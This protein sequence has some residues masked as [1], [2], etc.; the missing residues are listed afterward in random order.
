VSFFGELPPYLLLAGATM[1]VAGLLAFG[2]R[3]VWAILLGIPGGL[4]RRLLLN[5]IVGP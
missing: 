5:V 1:A 4:L 3:K 2:G